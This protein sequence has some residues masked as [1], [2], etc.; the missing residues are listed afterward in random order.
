MDQFGSHHSD[1][2]IDHPKLTLG[3]GIVERH[4]DPIVNEASWQD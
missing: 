1:S 3:A 4:E 2:G